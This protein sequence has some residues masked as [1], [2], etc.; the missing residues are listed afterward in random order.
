MIPP[1]VSRIRPISASQ[2]AD[3]CKPLQIRFIQA[4]N[5][6][7]DDSRAVLDILVTALDAAFR[8]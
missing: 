8:R 1:S 6:I 5:E 7:E 3:K 2:P 4:V